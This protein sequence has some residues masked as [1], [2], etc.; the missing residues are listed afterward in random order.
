MGLMNSKEAPGKD[1]HNSWARLRIAKKDTHRKAGL[2][3]YC[4]LAF[5]QFWKMKKGE[6]EK[7]YEW[8]VTYSMPRNYAWY[9]RF[10]PFCV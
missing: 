9:I 1:Q 7:C 8:S 4:D 2:R 10:W 5:P 3:K 6:K